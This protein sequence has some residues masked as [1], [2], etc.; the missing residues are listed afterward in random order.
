MYSCMVFDAFDTFSFVSFLSQRIIVKVLS[1]TQQISVCFDYTI[2]LCST[3]GN[4]SSFSFGE[5]MPAW[6][7]A[8]H[9]QLKM[10]TFSKIRVKRTGRKHERGLL[11]TSQ[12]LNLKKMYQGPCPGSKG[13]QS[14]GQSQNTIQT[15]GRVWKLLFYC[16]TFFSKRA[17]GM[18][19]LYHNLPPHDSEVYNKV[20]FAAF[21]KHIF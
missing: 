12:K 1:W 17:S 10:F 7:Q 4:R 5:H 18:R 9:P 15:F 13:L 3:F 6:G 20:W 14:E 8:S 16:R 19:E 2:S 21:K 11:K